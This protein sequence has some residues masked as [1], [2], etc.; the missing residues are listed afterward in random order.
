MLAFEEESSSYTLFIEAKGV[1]ETALLSLADHIEGE[2]RENHHYQYCR[3]LGQLGYLRVFRIRRGAAETHQAVCRS[4]GQ[5]AGD[6][7][8]AAL[9]VTSDWSHRFEGRFLDSSHSAR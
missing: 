6:V 8:P 9:H 3:D 1:R 5:R 4:G 7:K 2:L